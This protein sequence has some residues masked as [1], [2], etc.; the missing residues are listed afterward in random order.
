LADASERGQLIVIFAL[1]LVTIVA[2]AALVLEAGNVFAQQRI[3]QN[4]ADA[5]ANAGTLV[6]A[7]SLKGQPRTG[8]DVFNAVANS[9]AAN[10]LQNPVAVYTDNIGEPLVPTVTVTAGGSIPST[11]RGVNVKGDRV[12]GTT[13]ARVIGITQLTAS[14]QATAIAGAASGG[15]PPDT[16]CGLLPVTFPVQISVCDGSGRLTGIGEPGDLWQ[17]VDPPLTGANE[18][19][20][21]LCKT[22]PGAVGWL[23]LQPGVNLAGEIVTPLNDFDYPSWVQTQPGAPN[24][25]EDEL[26][27][28]YAGKI[29]LIPM[30]DGTCRIKPATGS[31][32]CPPA[33]QG[34]D[35]VG[36]NTYYHIPYLASF[37]LDEAIIQGA[38]VDDC[39]AHA[40]TPK[41]ISTTPEFLGCLTGWFVD[42]SLPGEV[43]PFTTI[44]AETVVAIQ[45]IK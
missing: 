44:D 1:A 3:A 4:G 11:A 34:V 17:I 2:M 41:L 45:L 8:V 39:N 30:F 20:V 15:C 6:I 26:N 10:Q 5:T 35:P 27:D 33:D 36:N 38:N 24:S 16:A 42:Y 32:P 12:V 7:Q 19:I 37:H 43:D 9:A 18:S 22:A 31:T 40:G 29:V 21:P 23:D 25:V 14:A 13:L 28:N